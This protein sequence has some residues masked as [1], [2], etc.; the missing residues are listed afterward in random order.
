[1]LAFI[2]NLPEQAKTQLRKSG[3]DSRGKRD[4]PNA[5]NAEDYSSLQDKV[6]QENEV[7][8]RLWIK[9]YELQIQER[10]LK[11]KAKDQKA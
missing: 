1:M 8:S 9:I 2:E 6:V 10:E 3:S 7:V 11:A 5:E 4:I